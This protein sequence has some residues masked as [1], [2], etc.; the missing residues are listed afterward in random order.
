[1]KKVTHPMKRSFTV[2]VDSDFNF[3]TREVR[4]LIEAALSR[5][6]RSLGLAAK[7]RIKVKQQYAD[8]RPKKAQVL[9]QSRPT[10]IRLVS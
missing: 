4:P 3:S 10:G 6:R 8:H 1:M 2:I 5:R 9:A 7:T